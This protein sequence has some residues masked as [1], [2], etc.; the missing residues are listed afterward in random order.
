MKNVLAIKSPLN[1]AMEVFFLATIWQE[2]EIRKV[3]VTISLGKQMLK[4]PQ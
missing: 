4:N 1:E 3:L 2:D